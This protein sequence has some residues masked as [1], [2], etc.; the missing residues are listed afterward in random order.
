MDACT[1]ALFR[2]RRAATSRTWVA[3][4]LAEW[5]IAVARGGPLHGEREPESRA[6]ACSRQRPSSTGQCGSNPEHD[7]ATLVLCH[8]G[9]CVARKMPTQQEPGT[10]ASQDMQKRD[11]PADDVPLCA[12]ENARQVT[13]A[14]A[15]ARTNRGTFVQ[16]SEERSCCP[17]K[18]GPW[19]PGLRTASC[20]AP[21]RST[22][23]RRR[24][25]TGTGTARS[26][27]SHGGR[28]TTGAEVSGPTRGGPPGTRPQ[29]GDDA[30]QSVAV[31]DLGFVLWVL[32]H[33]SVTIIPALKPSLPK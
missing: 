13:V 27:H 9:P 5:R 16:R 28:R 18:H 22:H 24:T 29:S 12:E 30:V 21:A 31:L 2:L 1:V 32:G 25:R 11:S 15:D 10:C 6:T 14:S 4:R 23:R 26:N 7:L 3:P 19:Q 20:D 8:A 33:G 17:V